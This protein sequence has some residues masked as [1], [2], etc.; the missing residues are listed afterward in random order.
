MAG[1][2]I[3]D[4]HKGPEFVLNVNLP[5]GIEREL[6]RKRIRMQE[7]IKVEN[8]GGELMTTSKNVAEVFNKEHKNVLRDIEKLKCSREFRKLNF[9]PTSYTNGNNKIHPMYNLTKDGFTILAM[10]YTGEKAM[11]FKEKYISAFNKM[12]ATLLNIN[13]SELDPGFP[14][15]KFIADDLRV[16]DA[17]RILMY[18]K[19]FKETGNEAAVKALPDYT[20]EDI[21]KPMTELLKEHGI[22]LSTVKANKLL[23]ENGIL[24]IK[25]RKASKGKE[26]SFKSLTSDGLKYGKNLISPMNQK[27]TQPHY[28]VD[29]FLDLVNLCLR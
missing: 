17:G 23:L 5:I 2:G 11:E 4:I 18:G 22:K 13:K 16:S 14:A 1:N 28:F 24:E 27:E 26:K 15:L 29:S 9:E 3:K 10:G 21:T 7:L 6:I 25:T 12:G 20:E 8:I 19:Y